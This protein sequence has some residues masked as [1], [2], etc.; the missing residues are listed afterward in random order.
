MRRWMKHGHGEYGWSGP[1]T[2]FLGGL[3][4]P[5]PRPARP[6]TQNKIGWLGAVAV[7]GLNG[8]P[9]A[10]ATV[11]AEGGGAGVINHFPAN[12]LTFAHSGCITVQYVNPVPRPG[13]ALINSPRC[14]GRAIGAFCDARLDAYH[15]RRKLHHQR[16]TCRDGAVLTV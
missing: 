13:R 14:M 11:G 7:S 12:A 2:G 8:S 1:F 6:T 5:Q 9:G 10:S 16:R 15:R 4:R 3:Y